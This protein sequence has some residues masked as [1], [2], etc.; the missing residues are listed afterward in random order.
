MLSNGLLQWLPHMGQRNIEGG[1]C[2]SSSFLIFL[3]LE[4]SL[5]MQSCAGP[6]STSPHK[7]NQQ[8]WTKGTPSSL[9]IP[10]VATQHACSKTVDIMQADHDPALDLRLSAT[11]QYGDSDARWESLLGGN[12][13]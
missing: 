11:P 13:A 6:P 4:Q 5:S 1:A 9:E 7:A 2:G 10:L 3:V 8:I 12:D